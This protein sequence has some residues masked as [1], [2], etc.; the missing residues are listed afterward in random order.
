MSSSATIFHEEQKFRLKRQRVLL[1]I[2]PVSMTLLVIWQVILGHPWGKQPLSNNSVIGWLDWENFPP[3]L[4]MNSTI[5]LPRPSAPQR[6]C[7]IP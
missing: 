6:S 3:A 2:P 4:L 1:A 7:E 5:L